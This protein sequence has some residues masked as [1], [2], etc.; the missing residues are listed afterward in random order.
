MESAG[1]RRLAVSKAGGPDLGAGE[2]VRVGPVHLVGA[3]VVHVDQL[4]TED[5]SHLR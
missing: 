4:M 2:V 1:D 5:C 3:V